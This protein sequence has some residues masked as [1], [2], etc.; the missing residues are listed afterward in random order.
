MATMLV[1]TAGTL[2]ASVA[3]EDGYDEL[4]RLTPTSAI[5]ALPVCPSAR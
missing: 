3:S 2:P 5:S 4:L 1:A